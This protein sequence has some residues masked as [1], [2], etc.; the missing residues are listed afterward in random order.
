MR[1]RLQLYCTCAAVVV[2]ARPSELYLAETTAMIIVGLALSLFAVGILCWLLFT[3]A[4]YATPFLIG[5]TAA[6]AAFN[7]GAGAIGALVVGLVAS[8]V[9]FVACQAAFAVAKSPAVRSVIALVFAA[10]AAVAGFHATLGLAQ[11]G[12]SSELWCDLFAVI[13]AAIVG[14]TAFVRLARATDPI[15]HERSVAFISTHSPSSPQALDHRGL[16]SVI[17]IFV[18]A[19]RRWRLT[20][21][22]DTHGGLGGSV[23]GVSLPKSGLRQ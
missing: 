22:L 8:A 18:L 15:S 2:E 10:P 6:L 7:H 23:P 21:P 14:C 3:L 12:V 19:E 16:T 20:R 11:I 13:G 5:V 17:S 9:T 1:W 4:V